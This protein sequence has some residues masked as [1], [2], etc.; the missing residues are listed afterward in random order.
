MSMDA[1]LM[2][3]MQRIEALEQQAD[4]RGVRD[5]A[6][7]PVPRARA[8]EN[9]T[10]AIPTGAWT[11]VPFASEAY[12]TENIHDPSVSSGKY[13]TCRT[14]GIY[15][16]TGN[17]RWA[18]GAGVIR[19]LR[20]YHTGSP[21]YAQIGIQFLSPIA[22]NVSMMDVTTSWEL[23]VNDTIELQVYQDSGGNLNLDNEAYS[24]STLS[25]VWLGP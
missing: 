4:R 12:D 21:N 22:G 18:N 8:Y 17:I 25:L 2:R 15:Q 14:A 6:K 16:I 13:M 1:A 10:I 7:V 11:T 19:G 20:I 5:V 9:V 24:S 23:A 3:L